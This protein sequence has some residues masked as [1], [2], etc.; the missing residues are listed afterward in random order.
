MKSFKKDGTLTKK[1]KRDLEVA[2]EQAYL[3]S[4][5]LEPLKVSFPW[6]EIEQEL[7]NGLLIPEEKNMKEKFG[8]RIFQ[9]GR[10]WY[11]A[12]VN[13]YVFSSLNLGPFN[14]R[15]I[16]RAVRSHFQ[17]GIEAANNYVEI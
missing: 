14:T 7:T 8:T 15:A 1:F 10:S 11:V 12:I 13:K 3:T 4:A 5:L 9:D 2:A 6:K 16:A 17:E